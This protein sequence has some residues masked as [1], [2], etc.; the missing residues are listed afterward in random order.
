MYPAWAMLEYASRRLILVCE[1]AMI[2]PRIMVKAD[3]PQKMPVMS[4]A[5]AGN[6]V[7]NT[8]SNAANP[9]IFAPEDMKAVTA[10]GAP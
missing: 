4:E 8:R 6:A 7:A 2:L 1:I 3:S 9:A 5:M 10:E